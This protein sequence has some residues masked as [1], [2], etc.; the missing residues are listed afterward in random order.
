MI[1]SGSVT[2]G[3]NVPP[4]LEVSPRPQAEMAAA[5]G[6]HLLTMNDT[7]MAKMARL[8]TMMPTIVAQNSPKYISRLPNNMMKKLGWLFGV[9]VANLMLVFFQKK[10]Q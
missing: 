4:S 6:K 1:S 2:N 8:P 10:I 5:D 3:L 9:D 7:M